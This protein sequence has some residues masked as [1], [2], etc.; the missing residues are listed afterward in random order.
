M[1]YYAITFTHRDDLKRVIPLYGTTF[2]L[3]KSALRARHNNNIGT[4]TTIIR[5]Y[6][7]FIFVNH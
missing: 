6:C 3:M 4:S 1:H 2:S 7:D 5:I